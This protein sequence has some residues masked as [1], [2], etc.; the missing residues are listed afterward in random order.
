MNVS[1]A[2]LTHNESGSIETLLQ[3]LKEFKLPGDEIVVVDDLSTNKETADIL[4][5]H[6]SSG[7]ISRLTTRP[8]GNNFANQKNFLASLCE[9]DYIF[10]IDADEVPSD[11]LM[12]FLHMT[13]D[14][15]SEVDMYAV[16]RWNTVEGITQEHIQKLDWKVDDKNR[17]NWPDHQMRI[18]KNNKQIK[19]I[20][21]VHETLTGYKHYLTLPDS[22][23][24]TRPASINRLKKQG[25]LI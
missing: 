7:L 25:N 9:K 12:R 8:L 2:I 3:K 20:N 17:V 19:W 24:L 4:D 14:M 10:N 5:K 11:D 6:F 13:L 18:H 1:Y 22:M 16:P 23:C 15:N 21:S